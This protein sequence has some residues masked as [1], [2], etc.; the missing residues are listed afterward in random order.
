MQ[1]LRCV[2]IL[3]AALPAGK[4]TNAAAVLALTLG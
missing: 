4:A 3:N 1:D 2:M